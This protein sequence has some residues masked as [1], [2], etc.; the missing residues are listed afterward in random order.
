MNES[1]FVKDIDIKK[2]EFLRVSLDLMGG[3]E[4]LNIR[5]WT[6]SSE[7]VKPSYKGIYVSADHY[8]DIMNALEEMVKFISPEWL[9]K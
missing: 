4:Y 6:R 3:R 5:I 8:D 9:R 2:D 7:G 1:K